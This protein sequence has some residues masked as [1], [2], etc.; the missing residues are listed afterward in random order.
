MAY[1]LIVEDQADLYRR[2]KNI[3]LKENYEVSEFIPSVA[4]AKESILNR[5][6]DLALLDIN[7]KD[8]ETGGIQVGK[9][10]REKYNIPFIFITEMDDDITFD[11]ALGA[12]HERYIVK[13]KP[14]INKKEII[15]S[16]ETVINKY[17]KNSIMGLKSTIY[18]LKEFDKNDVKKLFID[19][20]DISYFFT[21]IFTNENGVKEKIPVNYSCFETFDQKLYFTPFTLR[22]LQKRIPE[23]FAKPN[24][25][26][27][28]NVKSPEITCLTQFGLIANKM[29]IRITDAHRDNFFK[30]YHIFND[31][32]K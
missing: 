2:M 26:Y 24:A 23:Y 8:S 7:L 10:L 4:E 13:T 20:V 1:I 15:R 21:G 29:E 32:R 30:T 3:L 6:P 14:T 19:F 9:L 11:S 22:Q 5:L 18:E 28:V 27:L 16:I 17:R 12:G 25:S 31:I